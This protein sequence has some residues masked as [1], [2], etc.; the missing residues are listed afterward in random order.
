MRI[1]LAY[2]H[3]MRPC[4]PNSDLC[5]ASSRDIFSMRT[6]SLLPSCSLAPDPSTLRDESTP[7]DLLPQ[8]EQ[9]KKEQQRR[10]SSAGVAREEG[11][12]ADECMAAGPPPPQLQKQ[13]QLEEGVI[14]GFTNEGEGWLG[15]WPLTY[16]GGIVAGKA[17][18]RGM[19]RC[20]RGG[21]FT[22]RDAAF[23]QGRMLPCHAVLEWDGGDAFAGP[24]AA[25][26]QP[27]D[28]ARG[29]VVRGRDGGRFQGEWPAAGEDND[30]F[31][32]RRGAAWDARDGR[33]WPVALD[34]EWESIHSDG[35]G[36][37]PGGAH[38]GWGPALGVME[39]PTA[40]QVRPHPGPPAP[41]SPGHSPE[42]SRRF[43]SCRTSCAALY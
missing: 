6:H 4:I 42:R 38:T 41:H 19:L 11:R 27:A 8:E 1:F 35:T 28:G 17:E 21:G 36:W 10:S 3:G 12:A 40:E 39:R 15:D 7:H 25:G 13:Q 31:G 16:T 9:E 33:V 43:R 20:A 22:F 30:W 5:K 18:G 34:G 23:S 2:W 26:G 29:A 24:L 32:P 37:A 14:E